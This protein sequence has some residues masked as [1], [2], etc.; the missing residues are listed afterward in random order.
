MNVL[1]C[2]T[3]D[4]AGEVVRDST[5]GNC[6]DCGAEVW[7]APSSRAIDVTKYLCTPCGI[8]AMERTGQEIMLPTIEQLREVADFDEGPSNPREFVNRFPDGFDYLAEGYYAAMHMDDG[9]LWCLQPLIGDR[10]R[11]T[12]VESWSTAGEH[13]CYNSKTAAMVSYIAGPGSKPFGWSRH[14]L[15]N[16]TFEYPQ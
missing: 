16:G 10:L 9:R 7:I 1:I 5:K 14:M 8:V 13:W 12:I 4:S 6:G 11:I 15:A 3:T 2:K